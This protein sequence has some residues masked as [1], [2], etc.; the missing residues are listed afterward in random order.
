MD[1][2]IVFSEYYYYVSLVFIIGLY[3]NFITNLLQNFTMFDPV[4]LL[5][6]M[7]VGLFAF[8][9]SVNS[10]MI[11]LKIKD[12]KYYT[13]YFLAFNDKTINNMLIINF[14]IFIFYGLFMIF[15]NFFHLSIDDNYC[16]N[17]VSLCFI[18]SILFLIFN[19]FIFFKPIV[20][21]RKIY[22]DDKKFGDIHSIKVDTKN[23]NSE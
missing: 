23:L 1:K 7:I 16:E 4:T 10:I 2:N 22:N 18:C 20:L 5:I 21:I 11:A 8:V 14:I 12:A 6:A 17:L 9:M 15:V 13:D 3:I 19:S